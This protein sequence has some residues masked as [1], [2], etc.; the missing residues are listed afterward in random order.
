MMT[1]EQPQVWWY[2]AAGSLASVAGLLAAQQLVVA[3]C[4]LLMGTVVLGALCARDRE[5]AALIGAWRFLVMTLLGVG[6]AMT[7]NALMALEF[8]HIFSLQ[9]GWALTVVG[10]VLAL[11]GFPRAGEMSDLLARSSGRT[12]V[13]FLAFSAAVM[14]MLLRLAEIPL[15]AGNTALVSALFLLAGYLTCASVLARGL[16]SVPADD[17]FAAAW[18]FLL[19]SVLVAA[20]L[21]PTHLEIAAIHLVGG[22][23]LMLVVA[24]MRAYPP[25]TGAPRWLVWGCALAL[26]AFPPSPL[27]FSTFAFL[28]E[29]M[30]TAAGKTLVWALLASAWGVTVCMRLPSF[31]ERAQTAALLRTPQRPRKL[32]ALLLVLCLL[33]NMLLI[34][35]WGSWN[36]FSEIFF[37]PA[38]YV[39]R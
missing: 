15:A 33:W 8:P 37:P 4:G 12:S 30:L 6:I 32:L 11:G 10:L 3:W 34:A 18:T 2:L 26:L 36:V 29:G 38:T 16:L 14:L 20:G 22:F 24:V 5:R 39:P 7:G 31:P 17:L 21:A 27:F 13:C 35:T 9:L 23:L 25:T 1:R 19:G 28:Q